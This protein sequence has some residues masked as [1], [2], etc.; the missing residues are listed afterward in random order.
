LGTSAFFGLYAVLASTAFAYLIAIV[1]AAMNYPA[2]VGGLI[3]LSGAS[4]EHD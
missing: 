4:K 2:T 1:S 3:I